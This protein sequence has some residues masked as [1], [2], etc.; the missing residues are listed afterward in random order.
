MLFALAGLSTRQLQDRDQRFSVPI[1]HCLRSAPE[2][3]SYFSAN[4][5]C[6]GITD[7]ALASFQLVGAV[8]KSAPLDPGDKGIASGM[9]DRMR[10]RA[11]LAAWLT[12]ASGSR[13]AR[14]RAGKDSSPAVFPSTIA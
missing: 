3:Q 11:H 2:G 5:D 9:R 13:A 12:M 8:V 14:S 1:A 10:S 4:L 6:F 7:V